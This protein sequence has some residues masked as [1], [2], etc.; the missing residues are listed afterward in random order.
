MTVTFS[1]GLATT[2]TGRAAVR[3]GPL[4]GRKVVWQM[5]GSLGRSV[6]RS[7]RVGAVVFGLSLVMAGSAVADVPDGNVV[8]ACRNNTTFTIRVIDKSAG[9]T[10]SAGE[11]ALSWQSLKWRGAWSATTAY[12]QWDVVSRNGSSYIAIVTGIPIGN[13]PAVSPL[14]WNLVAA[15]GAT[16]PAGPAGPVGPKGA[17]GGQGCHGC[18]RSDPNRSIALSATI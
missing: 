7:W 10:C 1:I 4:I 15:A 18:D 11:T 17:T 12:H 14:R 3:R 8:N 6:G 2:G 13:D 16:G 9:Q 5:R